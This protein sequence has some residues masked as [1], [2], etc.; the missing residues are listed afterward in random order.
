V[1]TRVQAPFF[2]R[3]PERGPWTAV[4]LTRGQFLAILGLSLVLFAF[5]GGPVWAHVRDR[6][7]VRIAVSYAVI[8]LAAGIA[9]RRNHGAR[10]GLLLGATVVIALIKLVL[11]AALL[12]VLALGR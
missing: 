11:T 2:G 3:L 12:V 5:V 10:P 7:G 4:G 9:L 6:H 8:P 1:P